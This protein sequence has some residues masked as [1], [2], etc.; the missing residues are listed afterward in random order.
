MLDRPLN[1]LIVASWY[2]DEENNTRG[3][4][5]EEQAQMLKNAGH[6]VLVLHPFLLGTFFSSFL[7]K[8]FSSFS[9]WNDIPLLRVGIK[10]PFPLNRK[11][12]YKKL[13]LTCK[14][15]L[16]KYKVSIDEFDIIHSH[17]MFMGG[18]IARS[19]AQDYKK[20]FYHTEHSSG[21]IFNTKQYNSADKRIIKQIFHSA[22][23][24]FFV[25]QF[26]LL[27]TL[28]RFS[29]ESTSK[30]AVLPNIVHKRFFNQ[31]LVNCN[32]N[33]F[34]YIVIANLIPLKGL[35]TLVRSWK[36]LINVYPNSMLTIAGNGPEKE[37][38][39]NLVNN[40]NVAMSVTFL[41]SLSREEV[42]EQI[43]IHHVLVSTSKI[44]TFGLTVAEAQA[45]GLP[46]VVTDSGGVR[47]IVDID[48]G[49][50]TDHSVL[51]IAKG[52]VK[53]QSNFNT[54]IA[55]NIRK[56]TF[57]K[58]SEAIVYEKLLNHYTEN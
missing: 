32:L 38:L 25:S 5:I 14:K 52:L 39:V 30:Y 53:I 9:D 49:I 31:K 34:S 19:L 43:S 45:M 26:S 10:P 57:N 16:K 46:V 40:L 55:G 24:V 11:I 47:D 17:V 18:F 6:Q 3:S 4:F 51:E 8:E 37:G 36:E 1:I 35:D 20:L 44:E 29:I 22:K 58:F 54:Y 28:N 56:Q 23:R 50:I 2:P 21:L 12:A 42:K 48:S 27:Q 41:P 15:E 13:Y 7:K 33:P